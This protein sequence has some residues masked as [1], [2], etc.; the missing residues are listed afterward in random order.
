MK[1]QIHDYVSINMHIKVKERPL[2]N[3]NKFKVIVLTC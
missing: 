3:V 2:N 1:N